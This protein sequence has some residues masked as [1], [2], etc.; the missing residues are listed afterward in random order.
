[1]K[2]LLLL[3]ALASMARAST[4]ELGQTL[5]PA[6]KPIPICWTH[7]PDEPVV[8]FRL[9]SGTN[10]LATFG[11]NDAKA[12]STNGSAIMF[13]AMLTNGLPAG[14]NS[15]TMTAAGEIAGESDPSIPL[16]IKSLGK[17]LAPQALAKP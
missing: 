7:T 17:P 12:L 1:M 4:N 13:Q 3:L 15:L 6:L 9:Y 2:T 14:T 16:P 5:V 10:L 8:T 11:T